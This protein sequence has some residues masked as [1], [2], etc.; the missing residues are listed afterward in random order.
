VNHWKEILGRIDHPSAFDPLVAHDLSSAIKEFSIDVED[1]RWILRGVETD[2]QK[3]RY[4]TFNELLEYCDGVA[5]AVGFASMAIFGADR[6]RTS[7]YTYFTGRALQLTNVLRDVGSDAAR[8]RIYLPSEDL[9]RFGVREK[10][11]LMGLYDQRFIDLM[12]FETQRVESIYV[13]AENSLLPEER[14]A[15]PAAEIMRRTYRLLLQR[16]KSKKY[17]IFH[18]KIRVSTARKMATVFSVWAP[19]FL[20]AS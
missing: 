18:K 13:Q 3:A 1:L 16:I 9:E 7:H 17:N 10:N 14:R 5:S 12:D 6:R 4:K 15:F 19:R 20:R 11:I 8:Q 2:L